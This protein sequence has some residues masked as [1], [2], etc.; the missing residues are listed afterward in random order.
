[1]G[2]T[3]GEPMTKSGYCNVFQLAYEDTHSFE[4]THSKMGECAQ[5]CQEISNPL[6]KFL[7]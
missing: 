6:L 3:I 4:D 7:R 5:L 2:T 1:M